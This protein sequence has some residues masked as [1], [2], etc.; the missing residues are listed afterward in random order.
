MT[1]QQL[2]LDVFAAARILGVRHTLSPGQH[3]RG[4]ITLPRYLADFTPPGTV[5]PAWLCCIC[6][7]VEINSYGVERSHGCCDPSTVNMPC[8]RRDRWP[9]WALDFDPHWTLHHPERR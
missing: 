5:I 1:T 3:Q 4:W 2:A 8:E 9:G 6:G 7:G